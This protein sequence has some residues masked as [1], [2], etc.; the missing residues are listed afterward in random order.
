MTCFK[1]NFIKPYTLRYFYIDI[2][3]PPN[4][5]LKKDYCNKCKI[6]MEKKKLKKKK[7]MIKHALKYGIQFID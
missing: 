3:K 6:I 2:S 7:K 1:C 4:I 5:C